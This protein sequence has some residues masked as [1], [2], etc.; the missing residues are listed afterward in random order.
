MR[1]KIID[2]MQHITSKNGQAVIDSKR[3]TASSF[4]GL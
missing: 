1:E 2:I 4:N 3:R